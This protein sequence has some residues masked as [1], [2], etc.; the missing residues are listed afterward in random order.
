MLE[1]DNGEP[2]LRWVVALGFVVVSALGVGLETSLRSWAHSRA[3]HAPLLVVLADDLGGG[4]GLSLSVVATGPLIVLARP[5]IGAWAIPLCLL[6][7]V[8]TQFAVR[9]HAV[10]RAHLPP[11]DRAR[12]PG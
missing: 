9:R 5:V 8:L 6:P 4:G 7:L 1:W 3:V 11:D 10:V 12:C 2:R